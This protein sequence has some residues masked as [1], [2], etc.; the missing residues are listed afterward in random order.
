MFESAIL[1]RPGYCL[2]AYINASFLFFPNAI[3]DNNYGI[4]KTTIKT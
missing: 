4:T 2:K 1:D 3:M